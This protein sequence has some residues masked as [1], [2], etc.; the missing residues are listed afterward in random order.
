MFPKGGEGSLLGA[1]GAVIGLGSDI[2]GSIRMPCFF[3]GVFGHKTTP[4]KLIVRFF[5]RAIYARM[6]AD[7]LIEPRA[8][9]ALVFEELER[10]KS[11]IDVTWA[12]DCVR[13][14]S[15]GAF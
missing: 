1:A 3:N 10:L 8:K 11:V 14:W 12:R 2:G 6:L 7:V 13:C 15:V 9:L 5:F 4:G